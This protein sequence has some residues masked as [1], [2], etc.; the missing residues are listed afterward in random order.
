MYTVPTQAEQPLLHPDIQAI[1]NRM[2]V[3][4]WCP[5]IPRCVDRSSISSSNIVKIE[6]SRNNGARGK[7]GAVLT[8][9]SPSTSGKRG[10]QLGCSGLGEMFVLTFVPKKV[11]PGAPA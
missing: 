6:S 10:R 4:A 8:L 7:T 11:V 1:P 2:S 5:Y 3:D 9:P